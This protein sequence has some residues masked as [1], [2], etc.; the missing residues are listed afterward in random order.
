MR[1]TRPI[2]LVLVTGLALAL[3]AGCAPASPPVGGAGETSSTPAALKPATIRLGNLPT[4]DILPLWVAQQKGL[5]EKAGLTVQ[6]VPFQSAQERDAAFTAKAI[7]GYMGDIIAASELSNAGFG[8]R[9]VTVCLGATPAEGRFGIVSSP[10]SGIRTPKQLA[11][12][13]VGT[14][15]GTVQEYVLDGLMRQA[16]V[17]ASQVKKEEVKKVPVRFQL[18]MDNQLK[19]AALPEPFLS[20]AVKQGAHLV[21]DDTKGENL[22]QTVLVFSDDFLA[23]PDGAEAVKRL[24]DAWDQGVALVNADPNAYRQLLVDKARLPKPVAQSYKINT[25]PAHTLPTEAEVSAV[26]T[27]MQQNQLLKQPIAYGDLTWQPGQALTP[28]ASPSGSAGATGSATTT[29]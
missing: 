10:S 5:F 28:S 17:G 16:G 19:A 29:P 2:A 22:S 21:A 4:E 27:W 25:Y 6:I 24:L 9:V 23:K 3:L 18:L 13:P 7:D 1:T 15:S 14:S 12:V 20:L 8:N 26:M 11:N